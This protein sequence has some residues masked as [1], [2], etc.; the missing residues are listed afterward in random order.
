MRAAAGGFT[1]VSAVFL[2]VVLVVLGTSLMSIST[3]QHT[4]GAQQVQVARANYAVRTGVEWAIARANGAGGC[5]V[6]PTDISPGGQLATFT[7]SVTCTLSSHT[8]D[9][10]GTVQPY[11]VVDVTVRSG[12]YGTPGFV[13]RRG[14]A[15]VLGS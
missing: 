1:L 5:P 7:V 14:Q 8:I 4:T 15:K 9:S 10:V 12:A 2:M 13:L 3:V 6:G 11:Y